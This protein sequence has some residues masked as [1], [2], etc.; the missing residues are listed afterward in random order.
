[1]STSTTE[2]EELILR[3]A[4]YDEMKI[5]SSTIVARVSGGEWERVE[6]VRTYYTDRL[7]R[8]T[9]NTYGPSFCF[10]STAGVLRVRKD[11]KGESAQKQVEA[12]FFTASAGA[13]YSKLYKGGNAKLTLA[14]GNVSAVNY[15][16]GAGLSTGAGIKDEAVQARA[17]KL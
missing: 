17:F 2:E 8:V 5:D 10:S 4:G 6:T 14:G 15:H 9:K 13:E 16:V 12:Q 11:A 3:A 1:M 7:C